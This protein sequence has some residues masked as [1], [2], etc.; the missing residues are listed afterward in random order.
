MELTTIF[1]ILYIVFCV[2]MIANWMNKPRNK[3]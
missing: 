1:V 2:F 3:K